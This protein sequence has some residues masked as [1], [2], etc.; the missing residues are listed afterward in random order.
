MFSFQNLPTNTGS[1]WPMSR[2]IWQMSRLMIF[3]PFSAKDVAIFV[4]TIASW[5]H[6]FYVSFLQPETWE[7]HEHIGT[8]WACEWKVD[9]A[10][11][12]NSE[13]PISPS[14]WI[15]PIFLLS[16]LISISLLYSK[17]HHFFH[18]PSKTKGNFFLGS[19]EV[20]NVTMEDFDLDFTDLGGAKNQPTC[21][22]DRSWEIQGHSPGS[23][24]PT[25][26]PNASL[27]LP[28]TTI[29]PANKGDY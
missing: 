12:R 14:G 19:A 5:V 20:S 23:S 7:T 26:L 9:L 17:E 8:K 6:W 15:P 18:G 29:R 24:L 1:Q 22:V 10:G 4:V 3:L 11:S 27:K 13:N 16:C 28:R 21:V 2:L 25:P